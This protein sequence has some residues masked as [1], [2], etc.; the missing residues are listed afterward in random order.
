MKPKIAIIGAGWA[1]LAAAVQLSSQAVVTVFEASRQAGGRARGLKNS[2]NDFVHID[3]GQ[4]LLL[5]AYEQ[6]FRLRAVCGINAEEHTVRLPS[7][8]HLLDGLDFK[9]R[10]LPAPLHALVGMLFAKSW[11]F[12]DKRRW[13]QDAY[14]LRRAQQWLSTHDTNVLAWLNSRQVPEKHIA[15]F[16]RPLVLA[17]MNTPLEVASLHTLAV[18]LDDGLLKKRRASDFCLATTDLHTWLVEPVCRY[19]QQ[20]GVHIRYQNRITALQKA[21][22]G[23]HWVVGGESFDRVVIATAPYHVVDVLGEHYATSVKT[24][25]D[26]LSYSAITTVYLRYDVPLPLPH[27]I[28]GTAYGCSQWLI[29]REKL[30]IAKQELAAVISVSETHAHKTPDEWVSAVHQDVLALQADMPLPTHSL[31]ITE[32]RATVQA[33]VHRA[34]P[35]MAALNKQGLYL[36]GDY[37]HPRYPATLEGAVQSGFATASMCV[38]DWKNA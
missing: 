10:R 36:A 30:L 38:A 13:L 17:T 9:T 27:T 28:Q 26:Q 19:L 3:N 31:V 16:W 14:A 11:T 22:D 33:S 32:K 12:A 25:F 7:Q 15:E 24:Y 29:N 23:R 6:V 2:N 5:G 21:A 18:V 20:L 34:L 8:W 35:P 4:H 1:G 37:C